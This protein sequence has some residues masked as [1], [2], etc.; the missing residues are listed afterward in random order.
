MIAML[1][2]PG[3]YGRE[4][5]DLRF[6]P[7]AVCLWLVLGMLSWVLVWALAQCTWSLVTW[8]WPT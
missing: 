2:D 7:P 3:R 6:R 1:D 4:E 8:M 5:E